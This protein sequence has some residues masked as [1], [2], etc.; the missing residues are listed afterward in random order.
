L[1]FESNNI[2]NNF[3]LTLLLASAHSDENLVS[4]GFY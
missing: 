1:L 3:K 2:S 4:A